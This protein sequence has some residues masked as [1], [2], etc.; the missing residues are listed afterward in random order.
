MDWESGWYQLSFSAL[1]FHFGCTS[2][3]W[4]SQTQFPGYQHQFF[5]DSRGS[6]RPLL[7]PVVQ[8]F[9]SHHWRVTSVF[10]VSI[11]VWFHPLIRSCDTPSWNV[12]VSSVFFLLWNLNLYSSVWFL[13]PSLYSS[14]TLL[15]IPTVSKIFNALRLHISFLTVGYHCY[16]NY[17]H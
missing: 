14:D 5:L 6:R 10:I 4:Q 11:Y 15:I 9:Q 1:K 16:V 3:S 13:S 7:S 2:Y 8:P 17:N 12:D